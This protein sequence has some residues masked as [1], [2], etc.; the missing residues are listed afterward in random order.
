MNAGRFALRQL[1]AV[2]QK[3]FAGRDERK[4]IPGEPWVRLE[5]RVVLIRGS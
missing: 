4:D 2:T 3:P 5:L 1:I